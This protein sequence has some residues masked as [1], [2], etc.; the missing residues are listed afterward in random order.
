MKKITVIIL[1]VIEISHFKSIAQSIAYIDPAKAFNKMMLDKNGEG[2]GLERVGTYK[3]KGTSL[4]FGGSLK[5]TVYTKERAFPDV[6]ISYNTYNQNVDIYDNSNTPIA[7]KKYYELD[8]FK[9]KINTSELN[10]KSTFIS[11]LV[12]ESND[13]CFFQVLSLGKKYTLFKKFHTDLGIVTESQFQADLRQFDL[14]T[15]YYYTES[16][17]KGVKKIKLTNNGIIKEFKLIKDVSKIVE[18]GSL[19]FN[20]EG[21]LLNVFEEINK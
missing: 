11:S 4:Y 3:V 16:G 21:L 1:I 2:A 9:V 13:N 18:E 8:S 6:L 7:T 14:L 19:I 10:T 15:D 5:G 12:L 20:P 17:V